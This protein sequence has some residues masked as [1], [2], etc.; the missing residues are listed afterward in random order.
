MPGAADFLTS[1]GGPR[2]RLSWAEERD[3]A[4][5]GQAGDAHAVDTLV[6][7]HLGFVIGIARKYRRYGVPMNDLVQ[8]GVIGLIRAIRKFDPS[9]DSR[10]S[11]YARWWIRAA[12][13]EHVVRS[14]SL[15]KLSTSTAQKALFFQLRKLMTELR[16]GADAV[17]EDLIRPL[18]KRLGVP[19]KDALAMAARVARF[20][21]SLNH[22]IAAGPGGDGNDEEWVDRLPDAGAS[23]EEIALEKSET[24]MRRGVI[25]R[26]LDRLPDRERQIIRRR[27][28]TDDKATHK[29]IAIDLGL[30]A[31]RVRQLE[32]AAVDKLRRW[33]QPLRGEA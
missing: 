28:L 18:A 30:S 9:R 12:I 15:V 33:L 25:A 20:D 11:T 27:F 4:L 29:T 32:K 23:P 13:Q 17:G 6:R 16:E 22:P 10:L 14:W 26:A 19:I 2:R 1:I 7:S 5:R 8:E 24:V 31:E 3:L 21:P